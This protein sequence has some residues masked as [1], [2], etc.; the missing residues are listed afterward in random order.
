MLQGL[1]VRPIYRDERPLWDELMRQH[2]YLG[3]HSLVGESLRY[4]AVFEG[5]WLALLGW[6]AAALKCKVRDQWIGWPFLLQR[7]RLKLIVNNSRFLILPHIHVP[8]LASRI[9]AL[10]VKRLCA[11]WQRFYAHPIWLA[12]TFV[13]PRHFKGTCYKAAGWNFL[14][15]THG[16]AKCSDHYHFH[17]QPKMVFVRPLH[18]KATEKLADPYLHIPLN[19][20]PKPIKL[21]EKHADDLLRRLMEI[22]DPRM[23]RGLRHKKLSVLAISICAIMSHARS[24]AAIAEWAQRCP[25]NMRKRLWCRYN[26]KTRQYDA[27]SEPT[28][29]R[30]L[31]AVDAQAVDQALC[32]WLQSF[33]DD[34]AISVDGK[35]LRGARQEN[36]RQLQLLSAFLQQQGIVLAQ[37]QVESKTNEITTVRPLLDPLDLEGRVVTL[38]AIHTQKDT[39]RYLVEEKH[40]DYLFTI[41]DNQKTLKEDIEALNMVDFPPSA[42]NHR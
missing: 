37:R 19:Q 9:L 27:P 23:A 14:G 15:Y 29:R 13:D 18:P 26:K 39:A 25:Q 21:S 34:E 8:H 31:Q 41:K 3:F 1:E 22:P 38:D 33:S 30:F 7:H 28:I 10:N 2:H 6:A 17:N 16:F 42:R 11:D 24:F 35:T 40:A 4:V 36:G 32:G 5:Q 20:P 12:E